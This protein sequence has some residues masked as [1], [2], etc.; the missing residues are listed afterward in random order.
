MGPGRYCLSLH[1]QNKILIVE[2]DAIVALDLSLVVKEMGCHVVGIAKNYGEALDLMIHNPAD[3]L[4]CDIN[5][6][7]KESGIDVVRRICSDYNPAV[8]YLSA[9]ADIPTVKMAVDTDPCGYLVKPYRYAELFA[10]IQLAMRPFKTSYNGSISQILDLGDGFQ[11]MK[12]SG[13]LTKEGYPIQL[14][15]KEQKLL[16]YLASHPYKIVDFEK[17]EHHIWP[18]NPISDSNRRTLIYRLHLKLNYQI[19]TV[20]QGYGCYLSAFAPKTS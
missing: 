14:T 10:L 9:S 18:N 2:D 1:L 17:L 5:L 15:F 19:V 20:L 16:F 12:E 7:T 3:I 11:L 6:Q 4:L 13:I 8:I